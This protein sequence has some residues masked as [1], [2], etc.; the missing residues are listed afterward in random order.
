MF[1]IINFSLTLHLFCTVRQ[2]DHVLESATFV[3]QMDTN[4]IE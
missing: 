1:A 4:T 2:T 3:S